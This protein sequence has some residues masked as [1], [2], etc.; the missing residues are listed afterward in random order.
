MVVESVLLVQVTESENQ[1]AAQEEDNLSYLLDDF[2]I[3]Q[4]ADEMGKML[5][6]N[7][8]DRQYHQIV[9]YIYLE[10]LDYLYTEHLSQMFIYGIIEKRGNIQKS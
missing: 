8:R 7:S 4:K 5:K 10:S 2:V 3:E 1:H 9:Q 6:E